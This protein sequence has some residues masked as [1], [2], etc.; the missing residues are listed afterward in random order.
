MK[1]IVLCAG[2]G[3]RLYPLTLS[4]SKHLIPVANK[5]IL[6]YGL[7][8][9]RDAG[10]TEV[11][12]VVS[13]PKT[14]I[15]EAVGNGSQFDL[16]ITYIVQRDPK[17]LA[18]AVKICEDFIGDSSFLLFLGDNL[19]TGGI[20]QFVDYYR[21]DNPDSLILLYEVEDPERFG[22]AE[23]SGKQIIRVHEK[24]KNPP[25]NLAII[26]TYIFD[27]SIFDAINQLKPS[28]R[29]EYEITDAI[30]HLIDNKK[31][32]EYFKVDGWWKDTG[33]PDDIIA[34]NS[35]MLDSIETEIIG[36]VDAASKIHGRVQIGKGTEIVNSTI[37]GPVSI[38]NNCR[39]ENSYV[40][41]Y[42]SIGNNGIIEESEIEH[43]VVM[44]NSSIMN[45]ERRI[46]HSLIGRNIE[47]RKKKKR[48]GVN[49]FILCDNSKVTLV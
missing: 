36:S 10:I 21:K 38:G 17:G 37:S 2:R 45:I 26:G 49:K 41:S 33:I 39:I 1:A 20:N 5:P 13:E 35:Y 8:A 32:V 28:A 4:M 43:S 46:G 9:I 34:A 14:D 47:L 31:V 11:A 18:H 27:H 23:L 7:Q 24:P 6:F 15:E 44:E 12:I 42:C 16:D 29:G 40:G 22:V 3:T 25:T 30:Q 19:I 48:P